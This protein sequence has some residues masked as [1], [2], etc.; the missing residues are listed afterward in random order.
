M[1]IFGKEAQLRFRVRVPYGGTAIS[2]KI[3]VWVWRGI[4]FL[5]NIFIYYYA[6]IFKYL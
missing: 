6:Y 4:F 3:R 1:S 2:K 5:L